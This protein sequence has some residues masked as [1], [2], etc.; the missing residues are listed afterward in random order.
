LTQIKL[1]SKVSNNALEALGLHVG[2]LYSNLG[3]RI[4]GVVELAAIERGEVAPDEDKEGSVT[5][6]I[7]HLE[8]ANLEQDEHLREVLRA[9]YTHRTAYGKLTE[10]QEIELSE[11][12][13]AQC[14]GNVNAVEAARLHVAIER[15]EEYARQALNNGRLTASELRRELGTVADALRCTIYPDALVPAK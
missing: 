15:W 2:A 11:R 7:K 4:V 13:I 8:I 3:K 6:Q 1:A 12:T 10:D 14:A 5:L 9:L